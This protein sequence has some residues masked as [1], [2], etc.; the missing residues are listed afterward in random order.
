GLVYPH[1]IELQL[2]DEYGLTAVALF[3]ALVAFAWSYRRRAWRLGWR[4]ESVTI[5][6]LLL[7]LVVDAQVSHGLNDTRP[8][9]LAF[10]LAFASRRFGASERASAGAPEPR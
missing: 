5:G 8:M 7:V 4:A 10:G 2:A 1:N 3:V 9:W 6:A